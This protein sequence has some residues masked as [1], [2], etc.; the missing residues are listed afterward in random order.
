MVFEV[1]KLIGKTPMVRL[2]RL[3]PPGREICVKLEYLNPTG[4]HK[5]RAALY[6]MRDALERLGLREGDVVVEAS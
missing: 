5:D 2:G 1:V 3:A 6:M 4:S